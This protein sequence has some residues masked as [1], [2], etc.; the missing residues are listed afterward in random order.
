MG[1]GCAGSGIPAAV[2]VWVA[3]GMGG[4]RRAVAYAVRSDMWEGGPPDAWATVGP[5]GIPARAADLTGTPDTGLGRNGFHAT[6]ESMD[7]ALEA[8]RERAAA[9]R[10]EARARAEALAEALALS[11]AGRAAAVAG[12]PDV[13][14]ERGSLLVT[15][16]GYEGPWDRG[17]YVLECADVAAGGDDPW[18][19][20]PRATVYLRAPYGG[21]L[22]CSV[23]SPKWLAGASREGPE[24]SGS[25]ESPHD[26]LSY[27]YV[28]PARG[29]PLDYGMPETEWGDPDPSAPCRVSAAF[30]LLRDDA[31]PAGRYLTSPLEEWGY[32]PLVV[33]GGTWDLQEGLT[34]GAEAYSALAESLGGGPRADFKTAKP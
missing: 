31:H 5:D 14:A 13:R 24:Y 17:R 15:G 19:D 30:M 10:S 6:R 18:R 23:V 26:A 2:A 11:E 4:C 8:E 28:R 33:P 25:A 34:S 3:D 22:A 27:S 9:D 21:E 32:G 12:L 29:L 16:C 7:A 1:M 20:A